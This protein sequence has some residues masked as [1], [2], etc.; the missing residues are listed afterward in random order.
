MTRGPYAPEPGH[1]APAGAYVGFLQWVALPCLQEKHDRCHDLR[2]C[3]CP[4]HAFT[5]GALQ[6]H[7]E[8]A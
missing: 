8:P 6:L 7:M 2:R 5:T 3:D 4:C 1:A